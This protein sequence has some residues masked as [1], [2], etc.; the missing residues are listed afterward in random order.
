MTT[1]VVKVMHQADLGGIEITVRSYAEVGNQV[2]YTPTRTEIFRKD[3]A[4]V[5]EKADAWT[6]ETNFIQTKVNF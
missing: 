2:Y 6:G 1:E 3:D 4:A 5:F